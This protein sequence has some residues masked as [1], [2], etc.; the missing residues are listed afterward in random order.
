MYLKQKAAMNDPNKPKWLSVKRFQPMTWRGP[1]PM[2]GLVWLLLS[3]SLP[4]QSTIQFQTRMFTVAETAGQV[5]LPVV[6]LN[7]LET[8]VAVEFYSVEGT[9]TAGQD[10]TAVSGTLSFAAGVTN[11]TIHVPILNDALVESLERFRVALTNATGGAVLGSM[12]VATVSIQDND[13][14][15]Y[16]ASATH[17][18]AE[19]V[20]SVLVQVNWV[21]TDT[22]EPQ[23][24]DYTTIDGTALAGTDYEAASGTLHFE[25]H[26]PV[27]QIP[28][29]ILNDGVKD[30][31]KSF[32]LQLSNASSVG[33]GDPALAT[34]I[35]QDPTPM[36]FTQ[37]TPVS[38]SVSL[39]AVVK[40]QVSAKGARMQ[41]QKRVGEGEFTDI[42]GATSQVLEWSS[43][44]VDLSGG[45]RF[46]VSS[47]TGESVTSQIASVEV[48]PTFTKITEGPHVT[49]LGT[50]GFGSWG[51]Y[52]ND[53]YQDLVVYRYPLGNQAIYRNN[54]D[55]T[56]SRLPDPAGLTS[57]RYLNWCDW[58]ND[59]RQDLLAWDPTRTWV[60]FGD[61][62]GGYTAASW[63]QT[64][65]WGWY[66]TADYDRDGWLDHYFGMQNRLYRNL[67]EGSFGLLSAAEVGPVVSV[68]TY[69]S[70][71]WGDFDDDGWPDLFL[72][73]L[74]ESRSYMFRNEGTGRFIAVT[75]LVT[76]TGGPAF[77]G[78]WGDYD[79]DGRLDLCVVSF[80]GISTVYRNL[81]NGEFE[82]PANVPTLSSGPHNFAAWIDYD[83]DG[84]LDLWVSGYT[85]ANKLFRNNGDG[86]FTQVTSGSIVNERPLNNAGTYQ[87]AWFDYDNDGA[88]D[89]YVM[90]GDDS[91][92][93]WT[94]NQLF[95]NNGNENAWLTVKLV[96]TAS[97][98]D[99]VGAKV[100]ALATYA[101]EARWQRREITGGEQSNG[102]H[103]HAHFG[104][105][106]ATI[107]DRLRIE[108][109]SGIV[110]ELKDVAVDQILQVVESQGL[111]MPEPP[112]IQT[113]ELDATGVFHAT[114]NCPVEGA[115]CVLESSSDLEQWSKVRVGTSSGGTVELTDARAGDSPGKFYRVL[116]P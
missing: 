65:D 76:Q 61:G 106:D 23:T 3:L 109:P 54:G 59:G 100:R 97:N 44:T 68:N 113:F 55:G 69:G 6:R 34:V 75:N 83:N 13:T 11:Q 41:W 85:S 57:A 52:D 48:D 30:P 53:G 12:K 42:P 78:A 110:Q 116:I 82:R 8:E 4:A 62:A 36:I 7:D 92:S 9:A 101:G 86:S 29:V 50:S 43:A 94:V 49:D 102:N 35:I 16:F 5:A 81:G 63:S 107:V 25:K 19:D 26:D 105:G 31:E 89:L 87:V 24:V 96:G 47:S 77:Q 93:I 104:F 70:I 21:I 51:D 28:I 103:R 74:R 73:S 46:V 99:A 112:S 115:F 37:P 40:I 108:W 80:N 20:G 114:V 56:F 79:N 2:A 32:Q 90:N 14:G 95:H 98:R 10:F 18:V 45:Y 88:L 91:S 111:N 15:P 71:C 72:P 66:G 58:D 64:G 33:L 39:G 38:Q 60:V 17:Q 27:Q 22:D 1:V 67:G 84:F